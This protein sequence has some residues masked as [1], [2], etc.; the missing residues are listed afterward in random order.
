MTKTK[1]SLSTFSAYP[2]IGELLDTEL[3]QEPVTARQLREEF[4]NLHTQFRNRELGRRVLFGPNILEDSVIATRFY[5]ER[6]IEEIWQASDDYSHNIKGGA[7]RNISIKLF[8]DKGQSARLLVK[9]NDQLQ[10]DLRGIDGQK[11]VWRRG[12]A[13]QTQEV[14]FSI[15][16]RAS[17]ARS[18]QAER[19]DEDR[20]KAD[21][22]ARQLLAEH[23]PN[24]VDRQTSLE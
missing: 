7:K 22:H 8:D 16:H 6:G 2:A 21:S 14:A 1:E 20:I 17:D 13:E 24:L 15:L 5:D 4:I 19:T 12:N 10:L 23:Y 3:E 18:I 11:S 9:D